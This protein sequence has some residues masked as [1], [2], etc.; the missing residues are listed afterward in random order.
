MIFMNETP[1]RKHSLSSTFGPPMHLQTKYNTIHNPYTIG[2]HDKT[3]NIL[4]IKPRFSAQPEK[5]P[6]GKKRI[7][8]NRA[9]S[10][11]LKIDL[12][13]ERKKFYNIY[14]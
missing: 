10:R 13:P 1:R 14:R 5:I 2:N 3:M 4:G 9:A 12:K 7:L 8:H 11:P 6:I